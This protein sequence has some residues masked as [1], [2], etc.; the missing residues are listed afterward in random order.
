MNGPLGGLCL[1]IFG[2]FITFYF[3]H[4]WQCIK[5][6]IIFNFMGAKYI[7]SRGYAMRNVPGATFI[8]RAMS[9]SDSR[10]SK[11]S[12]GDT[13]TGEWK[14]GIKSSGETGDMT[15][16]MFKKYRF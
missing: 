11:N 4:F 6:E 12:S 14:G 5:L 8:Q 3:F 9:I 2:F 10:V 7:Y 13:G 16:F 1:L 15:S